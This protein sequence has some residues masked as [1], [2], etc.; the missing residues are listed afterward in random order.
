MVSAAVLGARSIFCDSRNNYTENVSAKQREDTRC[1]PG[2]NLSRTNF[3]GLSF[4][5]RPHRLLQR[6]GSMKSPLKSS[7]EL[8]EGRRARGDG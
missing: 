3:D 6:Q 7:L 8:P 5:E 4:R 2:A 1:R